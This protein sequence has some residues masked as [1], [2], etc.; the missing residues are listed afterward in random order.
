MRFRTHF[1]KVAVF[2]QNFYG[3]TS[4]R[5]DTITLL[6]PS[7]SCTPRYIKLHSAEVQVFRRILRSQLGHRVNEVTG[8][9]K[10]HV[11]ES[12]LVMCYEIIPSGKMHIAVLF[13]TQQCIHHRQAVDYIALAKTHKVYALALFDSV[14]GIVWAV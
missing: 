14:I 2:K 5:K 13:M 3:T 8:E 6:G 4:V 10:V 1:S 12:K 7:D 11:N 9:L